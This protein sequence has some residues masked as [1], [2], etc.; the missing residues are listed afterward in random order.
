MIIAAATIIAGSL[1]V[2]RYP[3]ELA[4]QELDAERMMKAQDLEQALEWYL[5]R[6]AKEKAE[7]EQI[8]PSTQS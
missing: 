5:I 3:R 7:A 6:Q 2:I 4:R 1:F 8:A